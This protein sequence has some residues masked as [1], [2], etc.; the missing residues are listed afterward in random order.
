MSALAVAAPRRR[1][2]FGWLM[3]G[4][5]A[6]T[7][8]IAAEAWLTRHPP[9]AAPAL[10]ALD[11]A[12][13]R[14]GFGPRTFAAALEQT[15][16]GIAG[17]RER[18]ARHPGE[19]LLEEGLARALVARFRLTANAA[20]LAEADRLLDHAMGEAPWPAGP[21][22]TRA[23][24]A[25]TVH[26]LGQTEAAL[27]RLDAWAVRPGG[28]DRLDARSM[29]CEIAFERGDPA[30]ARRLCGDDPDGGIQ[31]RLA[32]IAAK[33]GDL[34]GAAQKIEAL[35]RRPRQ[36][37]S[38]LAQLAL[39][40]AA[41]ALAQGD[42]RTSGRWARAAERLFPG[43][44]LSEAYIAQQY[45]L[46]GDFAEA[47]RRYAAL[48]ARTG[49]AD[50]CDALA[51]LAAAT[52]HADEARAWA[53]RAEAAWQERRRLLPDTYAS[54][55]AE[56]LLL[57]G[58]ATAGLALA[59]GDYRRRPYPASI[60]HYAFALWRN[61][62]PAQALAVV[63]QGEAHGFLTADM[64]LAEAVSLAALGRAD[65][66]GETLQTARRLNPRIDDFRQQFVVFTQD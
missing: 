65:D 32:N 64:K 44:W 55:Y 21:V 43:W 12:T 14:P 36:P 2:A 59:A 52:G 7:T 57:H 42:W 66:A 9:A 46:E 37:P 23:S 54:H 63:R 39:Q 49:D 27:K 18:I 29:R 48:A 56:H 15:N 6:A 34:P 16:L 25:L 31:L 17:A 50:V 35:L 33:T 22:L 62:H 19:W 1:A 60:A 11:P 61:G 41:V 47:R 13:L 8:V 3:A 28:E 5:L 26:D 45:A 51:Q 10:P 40:R 53:A 24:V 58:D 20:D 38:T 30:A 4:T